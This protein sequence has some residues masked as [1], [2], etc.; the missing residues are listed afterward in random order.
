MKLVLSIKGFLACQERKKTALLRNEYKLLH[1]S[2]TLISFTFP[3]GTYLYLPCE[4][5]FTSEYNKITKVTIFQ[6][7]YFRAWIQ[8]TCMFIII[9]SATYFI[10]SENL[11][12][13]KK[14]DDSFHLAAC[15]FHKSFT[16]QK[17]PTLVDDFYFGSWDRY[18]LSYY[19]EFTCWWKRRIFEVA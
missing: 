13:G 3:P 16:F 1:C 11:T 10:R 18:F 19:H 17:Q 12:F 4:I 2:K 9:S 5:V 14:N 6:H 15:P 8:W 7:H